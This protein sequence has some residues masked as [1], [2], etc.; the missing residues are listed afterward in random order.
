MSVVLTALNTHSL[1]EES[2]VWCFKLKVK[3]TGEMEPDQE[4]SF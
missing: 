4:I 2:E 1:D 3:V